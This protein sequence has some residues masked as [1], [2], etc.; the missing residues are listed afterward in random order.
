M[1]IIGCWHPGWCFVVCGC[2]VSNRYMD[3]FNRYVFSVVNMHLDDLKFCI[4]CIN[5][6]RYGC[7]SECYVV[8]NERHESTS[9][10]CNLSVLTLVKLC[11]FGVFALDVC[12]V[13]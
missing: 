9:D 1:F 12:L 5:G 3:V 4:V 6:R 7:C 13:S 2:A 8:S 10:L 11:T